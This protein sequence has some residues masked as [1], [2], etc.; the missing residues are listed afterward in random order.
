L[1]SHGPKVGIEVVGVREGETVVTTAVG[2]SVLKANDG[3]GVFAMGEGVDATG[4]GVLT[5]GAGVLP[6]RADVGAEVT[7]TVVDVTG[8]GF[9]TVG[10]M[11]GLAGVDDTGDWVA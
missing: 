3:S 10:L 6:M 8:L 4:D 7:V 5:I 2:S 1:P 9:V 11:A